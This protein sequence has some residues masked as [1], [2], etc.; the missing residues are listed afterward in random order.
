MNS[1]LLS[2]VFSLGGYIHSPQSSQLNVANKTPRFVEASVHTRT[3]VSEGIGEALVKTSAKITPLQLG[4]PKK[5]EKVQ[6]WKD[7][8]EF[9]FFDL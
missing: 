8:F 9:G 6:S 2:C 7:K 5:K 3:Y 1:F 4:T